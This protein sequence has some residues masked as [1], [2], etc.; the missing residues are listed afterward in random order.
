MKATLVPALP[1]R[2]ANAN[3]TFRHLAADEDPDVLHA[4]H[5]GRR[6]HDQI[7]LLSTFE[8]FP[9]RGRLQLLINEA[10]AENQQANWLIAQVGSQ[11][12]GYSQ[13]MWWLEGDGTWL[14]LI[15]GWVLPA[16]RGQGVGTIMLTWGEQRIRQL[17]AEQHPGAPIEFGANAS[18]TEREATA[19]L[20]A[21]GYR[22]VYT[23]VELGL[24]ANTAIPR[25]PLPPGIEVRPVQID[26]YGLIAAS[27]QEAYQN[28]WEDGRFDEVGEPDEFLQSLRDPKHDPTLWQVA[29]AGNQVVGQVLSVNQRGRAEVFEVSVRP[30]WRR[31]GLA[32]ALLA[33]ALQTLRGRGVGVIRLHTNLDFKTKAVELYQRV[34]FR[35]LKE[36]PRYRK[37]FDPVVQL[38][39]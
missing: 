27:V 35:V 38:H 32:R 22:V 4:L 21:A 8:D 2:P 16:W 11:V 18:S 1:Y 20:V 23:M 7:D 10:L 9:S 12:I 26:Y 19:L 37:S 39:G 30:A 14:Y 24:D 13:L 3:L 5:L 28:E 15:K 34:G 6:D 33:S 31:R 25:H 17:A 29:W 36:F